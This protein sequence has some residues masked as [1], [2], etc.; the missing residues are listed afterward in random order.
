MMKQFVFTASDMI[1]AMKKVPKDT[2]ILFFGSGYYDNIR[3]EEEKGCVV[4]WSNSSAKTLDE[5]TNKKNKL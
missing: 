4:L 1:E 3:A 2:P 5:I